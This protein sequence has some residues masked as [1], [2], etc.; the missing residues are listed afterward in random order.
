MRNA[1]K[2]L[3]RLDW[4]V[5]RRL[6]G[7]LQGDYRTL[8]HGSGMDLADLREY[9]LNDD[10]R[11]IDWN[12]TAR[13]Q[14]PYVREYLEDRDITAW[15][16]LDVSPSV[17]FG[18]VETIKRNALIDF[19][20]VMARLLTRNG[21]RVGGILYGGKVDGLIPALGGRRHVLRLMDSIVNHPRLQKAPS[22]DLTPLL[23]TGLKVIKRRSVV[24]IVSDFI[25]APG[26]ERP[27]GVLARRHDIMAVRLYDPREMQLPD[28]GVIV[29]EDSESGEQMLVD[30][31]DLKF[32]N[33]FIEAG[34]KRR[35]QVE[36]A[37]IKAGVDVMELST[38]DDLANA[39]VR[40]AK[41]RKQ[42]RKSASA[43]G[44]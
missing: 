29:M 35:M 38:E 30:T 28:I 42:R 14:A 9:Q 2:I 37:C 11:N 4:T 3:R 26:W 16:L 8:F 5:V 18:T 34:I 12:V 22:T 23:E 17:D 43:A 1:E 7:L 19:V 41:L 24:F 10:V 27:L 21:N 25:S 36:T 20:A 32:R 31:H 39:L 44:R 13:M 40:Q 15:F 33:R 6:D